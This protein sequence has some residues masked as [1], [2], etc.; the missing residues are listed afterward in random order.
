VTIVTVD[1]VRWGGPP[2]RDEAGSPNVV[3]AVALAQAIV[4]LQE[5]GMDALARHEAELT[6]HAL[7]RLQ[8]ID[9]VEVHGMTDPDRATERVGVIPFDM[10]GTSHYLVAAALSFEGGI[11]V[12]NGCFCAHPYILRLLQV[13]GEEALRH[14]QDI[15]EGSRVGLPGLVRIS[16]GCYNTIEEVD[17]AVDMLA[18]IAAGDL[19]GDYVQDP[20]SGEY[21]P[22]GYEPDY[23]RYFFL[24]PGLTADREKPAVPRC[25][26]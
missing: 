20:I 23:N 9:E 26:V 19:E 11:A 25:G 2:D 7:R 24:A 14:Q 15:I 5:I 13:G 18:R 3:G 6:A 12:R 4:S 10:H 8:E 16:F 17:H 1:G 21:W 22:R